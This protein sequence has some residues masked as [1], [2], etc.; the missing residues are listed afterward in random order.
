M[1]S[2]RPPMVFTNRIQESIPETTSKRSMNKAL[3]MYEISSKAKMAVRPST[4][5][6]FD[7]LCTMVAFFDLNSSDN[8]AMA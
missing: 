5:V 1:N 6:R 8:A 3:F 2:Y 4:S 7:L